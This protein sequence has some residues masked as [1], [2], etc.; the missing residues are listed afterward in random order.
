MEKQ[1]YIFIGMS[2]SGKGTQV[3]L[4]QEYLKRKDP[5]TPIFY[6]Q[7]GN[8]FREFIKGDTYAAKIAKEA[9]DRG[10]RA[11]DF[12]AMWLWSDTFVKNLTGNEHIIIDG[13]PRSLNEA[14]NLDI[15][16]K[17]F[18]R[19]QPV[20]V[21]LKV[22]PD[23]SYQH[24]KERAS[25]EGRKDDNDEGIRKRIAWFEQDV[26]PAVNYYRRDRDYDFIELNGERTIEEVHK[27]LIA[28]LFGE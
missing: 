9:I 17:F 16:M 24:L 25:K 6:Y 8:Q 19:E 3:A 5:E 23:W 1:T 7:S 11:P 22:S 4:L 15:N 20:V 13:S 21:H 12:L 14:Q 28:Q 10:E 18:R 26:L 2:G 27:E